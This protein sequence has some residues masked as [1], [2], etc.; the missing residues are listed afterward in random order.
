[1]SI[2]GG[3]HR[4]DIVGKYIKDVTEKE[5]LPD[6]DQDVIIEDDVWIGTNAIILKGVKI[7]RGSV[8][9]AGSVVTR[10]VPSYTIHVGSH[11]I[12]EKERFTKSEI[13]EHERILFKT[14]K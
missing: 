11:G 14:N 13:E 7:G 2:R 4:T 8:I 9:G 3:N 10:N 5:K 12:F 1:V 6:N